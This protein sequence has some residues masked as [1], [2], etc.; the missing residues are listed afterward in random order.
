MLTDQEEGETTMKNRIRNLVL[1]GGLAGGLAALLSAPVLQART[2]QTATVSFDSH[3]NS[4]TLPAYPLP[5]DSGDR[6]CPG[7]HESTRKP[8]AGRFLPDKPKRQ[9]PPRPM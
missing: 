1:A 9:R 2:G 6:G 7:C 8:R 4:A 5:S 3:L